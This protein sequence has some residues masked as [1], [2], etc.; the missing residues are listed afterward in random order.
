MHHN[1]M[2]HDHSS[3]IEERDKKQ[4][5]LDNIKTFVIKRI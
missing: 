2:L 5:I 1:E 4:K 3:T